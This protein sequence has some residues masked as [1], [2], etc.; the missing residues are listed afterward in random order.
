MSEF[1]ECICDSLPSKKAYNETQYST[2]KRRFG[3][4]YI[5]ESIPFLGLNP[6]IHLVNFQTK[7]K[8][9][10]RFVRVWVSM[11]GDAWQVINT[12]RKR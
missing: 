2:V 8:S 11:Y 6:G 1:T 12:R 7:S 3:N 4:G 9:I 5:Y 10:L